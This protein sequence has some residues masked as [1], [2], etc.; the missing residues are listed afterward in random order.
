MVSKAVDGTCFYV[1]EEWALPPYDELIYVGS[2]RDTMEQR[3]DRTVSG[4]HRK[5]TQYIVNP[6]R[7]KLGDLRRHLRRLAGRAERPRMERY[8]GAL[9]RLRPIWRWMS[10]ATP[11][12]DVSCNDAGLNPRVLPVVEPSPLYVTAP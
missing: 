7:R 8:A 6:P 1:E 3:H 11:L 9:C 5:A 12:R 10:D 4:S 2:N